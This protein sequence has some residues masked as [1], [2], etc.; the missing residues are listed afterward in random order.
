MFWRKKICRRFYYSDGDYC[1]DMRGGM[2]MDTEEN[3]MQDMGGGMAME[4][5]S[6]ELYMMDSAI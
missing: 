4:L 6:G 1:F 3:L 2:M 5:D